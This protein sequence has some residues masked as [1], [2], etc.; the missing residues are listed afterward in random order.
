LIVGEFTTFIWLISFPDQHEIVAFGVHMAI[1][2]I[3]PDVK[4]SSGKPTNV[5][6]FKITLQYVLK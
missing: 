2:S 6:M 1:Q 5:A 4:S 3:V